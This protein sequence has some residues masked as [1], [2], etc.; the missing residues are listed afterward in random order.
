METT[1]SPLKNL[2]NLQPM[3]ALI[4]KL[5]KKLKLEVLLFLI[6]FQITGRGA[7]CLIS[8]IKRIPEGYEQNVQRTAQHWL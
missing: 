2:K 8:K 7:H 5:F 1:T 3:D 6:F 4:L